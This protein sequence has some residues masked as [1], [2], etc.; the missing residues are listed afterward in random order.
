MGRSKGMTSVSTSSIRVILG[1]LA[2]TCIVPSAIAQQAG[3]PARGHTY[4]AMICAAC[5]AVEPGVAGSPNGQA[6]SFASVAN[7]SGITPLA[8]TAFFQSPH[9]SMPNLIVPA[10]D[11]RDLI[12]YILSLKR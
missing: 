9:P 12:A 8:L 6:P 5:H 7:S 2:A 10:Q 3:D 11:A 4:A 1:G